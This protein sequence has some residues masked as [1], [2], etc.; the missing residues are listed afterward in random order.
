MGNTQTVWSKESKPFCVAE[1]SA[2]HQGSLDFVFKMVDAAAEAGA[3]AIKLQT[4][5]PE[6][7]TLDSDNPAFIISNPN[8]PWYGK[9]LFDLYA[10][11]AM[12]WDWHKAIMD[13]AKQV[14]VT[15]FSLPFDS[16]SPEFLRR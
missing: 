14:G 2:N 9:R 6:S 7:M 12:P 8:S 16:E 13:R 3:D 11:A 4:Y 10:E 5:K 15:C 1:F